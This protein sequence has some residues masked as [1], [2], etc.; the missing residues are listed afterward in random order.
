MSKERECAESIR[1]IVGKTAF[2]T[3]LCKVKS[4]EGATCTVVREMDAMEI[5]DVR[6]NSTITE[7][8]GLVIVPKKDS[9]ILITDIDGDKWFVSQYS[10]IDKITIDCNDTIVINGGENHGLILIEKL[11]QKLKALESAFNTH[12]H[13]GDFSGTINGNPATGTLAIPATT[14]TS[15]NFQSQATHPY[16]YEN[17]KVQH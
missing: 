7:N 8:Q 2:S 3:Y 12:T 1:G 9:Y 10:D 17:D 11:Q 13:T 16:D 4:V 6:I 15:N 14:R 5:Q